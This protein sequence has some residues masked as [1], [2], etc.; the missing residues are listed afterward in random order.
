M[1]SALAEVREIP[2][3]EGLREYLADEAIP[4]PVRSP[5]P[6]AM[7]RRMELA[8]SS[9]GRVL[10]QF[11]VSL[12]QWQAAV[13]FSAPGHAK[14]L[15]DIV[16]SAL[17]LVGLLPLFLLI[18]LAVKLEDGGPVFFAQT[19]V[20]RFGRPFRMFKVRSMCVDAEVRLRELLARNQ[21]REGVTFKLKDDPR[22]TRVGRWLRKLSLDELPQLFNVFLGDMSLVGPRPPVPREV[23]KYTLSDR[24][25]LAIK[26]GITCI[27]QVSGRSE[28]DF[29]G[30]VKLDVRYIESQSFWL[31]LK[32]LA[33]TLPAVISGRGAC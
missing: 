8:Q 20:G 25:R 27:W 24:R 16:L 26:P 3:L 23:A 5:R 2:L 12:C 29:S 30:Q 32:L 22:I 31:D 7:L 17:L 15:A 10:L 13:M 19:R 11:Q 1:A 18:A 28:I 33:R 21:H 14:R 4:R 9:W 6:A